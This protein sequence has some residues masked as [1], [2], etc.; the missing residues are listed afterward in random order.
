MTSVPAVNLVTEREEFYEV[1]RK[2][3]AKRYRDFEPAAAEVVFNIL[4]TYNALFNRLAPKIQRFGLT[5]PG[6]NVLAILRSHSAK[7]C[8]LSRLSDLLLVS[9]ANITGL[10]DS[11]ARKGLVQRIDHEKDRRICLARI[12]SQG[13]KLLETYCPVHYKE[14]RLMFAALSDREKKTLSVILSKLRHSIEGTGESR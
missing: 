4:Q 13:E 14:T 7:R 3:F 2:D 8:S 11:L 5:L 6:F 10:I 9:R 12:T 1:S